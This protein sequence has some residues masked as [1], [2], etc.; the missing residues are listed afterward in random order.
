MSKKAVY[1]GKNEVI[2]LYKFLKSYL[3]VEERIWEKLH[4]G[5]VPKYLE[6]QGLE[7]L[8]NGSIARA[9]KLDHTENEYIYV[10]D[11]SDKIR[12]YRNPRSFAPDKLLEELQSVSAEE[13]EQRRRAILQQDYQSDY[14][15][16]S[17]E[18]VKLESKQLKKIR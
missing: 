9:E 10:K 15:P 13:L 5:E 11:V 4:H 12:C 17:G 18:V 8:R 3:G 2:G 7:P 16:I 1:K 6:T 14:D